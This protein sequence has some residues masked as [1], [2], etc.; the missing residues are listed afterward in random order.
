MGK[1]FDNYLQRTI[2]VPNNLNLNENGRTPVE[3]IAYRVNNTLKKYPV[4]E[5]STL[6]KYPEKRCTNKFYMKN[7]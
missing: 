4:N 5:N 1:V 7:S 2:L 6:Q 3:E